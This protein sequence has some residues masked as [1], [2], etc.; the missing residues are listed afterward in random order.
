MDVLVYRNRLG[1][2]GVWLLPDTDTDEAPESAILPAPFADARLS[3]IASKG[4]GQTWW[5]YAQFLASQPVLG[6]WALQS[7]PDGTDAD[8]ALAMV[9]R[10]DIARAASTPA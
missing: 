8:R 5:E 4:S 6:N 3:N 9:R 1:A 10:D 2:V 7:L